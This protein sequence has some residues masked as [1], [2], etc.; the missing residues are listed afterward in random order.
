MRNEIGTD[1]RAI[2]VNAQCA[3]TAVESFAHA[4]YRQFL[5]SLA[6]GKLFGL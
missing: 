4:Y 2:A 3:M 6:T 5:F 1:T